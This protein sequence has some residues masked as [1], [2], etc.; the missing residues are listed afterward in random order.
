MAVFYDFNLCP[1]ACIMFCELVGTAA[2]IGGGL[3]CNL[4]K[5]IDLQ[6]IGQVGL[7]FVKNMFKTMS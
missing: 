3:Y 2:S 5:A 6:Q 7:T 1:Y 4:N